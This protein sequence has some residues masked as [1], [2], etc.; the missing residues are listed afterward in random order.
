MGLPLGYLSCLTQRYLRVTQLTPHPWQARPRTDWSKGTNLGSW[1]QDMLWGANCTPGHPMKSSCRD[2][3]SENTFCIAP[4]F[5]PS[6]FLHCLI[7][8][9]RVHSLSKLH[10]Q[11]F[12]SLNSLLGNPNLKH[13]NYQVLNT[14]VSIFIGILLNLLINIWSVEIF[15]IWNHSVKNWWGK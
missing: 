2:I 9:F 14:C 4:S 10:A 8:F 5:F 13:F 12:Q 15:T 6:C 11:E 1:R 7:G 3:S